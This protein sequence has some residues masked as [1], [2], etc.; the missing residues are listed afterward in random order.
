VA[1]AWA[2]DIENQNLLLR[3]PLSQAQQQ[4]LDGATLR[5]E[6]VSTQVLAEF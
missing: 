1:R 5:D 4:A 2:N 6:V 3:L